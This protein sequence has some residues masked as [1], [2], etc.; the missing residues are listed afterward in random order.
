MNQQKSKL[1][2]QLLVGA[3]SSQSVYFRVVLLVKKDS[4]P[5]APTQAVG[6]F[7]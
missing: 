1:R 3:S 6:R 5:F 4:I 7:Q 2:R